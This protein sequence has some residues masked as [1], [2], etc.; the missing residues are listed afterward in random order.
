MSGFNLGTTTALATVAI[1]VKDRDKMIDFY[2]DLIGFVLKGEENALAIMGTVEDKSE[3]LWLEESPRAQDYFGKVKKLQH[4]T[5]RVGSVAEL[6]D[7]FA[8]LKKADYPVTI[9][10]NE[11][12]ARI[13]LTDPEENQLEI[14]TQ[15]NEALSETDL[16]AASTGEHTHLSVDSHFEHVH[17][18]V[19]D[20]TEEASFLHE[21]LGFENKEQ[22]YHLN[23][24]S[25][26][27]GLNK[28]ES[29]A[30]A[31]ESH[32]ILGLEF[33]KFFISE[34]NILDLEKHLSELK[35]E[36]FIDKKKSIL[37]IYDAVGIE[38][39]FVRH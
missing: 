31:V 37:T 7:I 24:Q 14:Y 33:L 39:W 30:I 34:E 25:F 9:L 10:L 36:F 20:V 27:V 19:I 22:G 2:S 29:E 3:N 17:L 38:W 15:V 1:R 8:R 18:N 35:K 28:A 5:L 26:H 6:S 16:L 21:I 32:E 12:E 23:N 13:Q 4:L 11:T